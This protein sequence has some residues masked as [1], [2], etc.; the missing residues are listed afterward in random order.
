M[1]SI[2]VSFKV[3]VKGGP[4]ISSSQ[5]LVVEAY[6]KIDVAIEPTG[7]EKSIEVQPSEGSQVSFLLIKSSLYSTEAGKLT[8][9]IDDAE[10]IVLDQ[11]H[12]FLGPGAVSV[13]GNAPKI[14]KFK[15]AYPNEEKNRAELE[16]LVGRDA[17]PE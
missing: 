3:Q 14:I 11:P 1:A 13:L 6:D 9:G 17:T 8:Y 15:N 2:D 5:E 10:Q 7:Q 4:L 16:I 12:L